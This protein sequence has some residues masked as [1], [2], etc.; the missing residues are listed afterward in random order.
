[1]FKKGISD[2]LGNK[3]SSFLLDPEYGWDAA[4]KLNDDVGLIMAYE[5]T[6]YDASE[7]G[8]LPNLVDFYAV[9]D[10]AAAGVDAIK[11]LV[12]YDIDEEEKYNYIKHVFIKRV[13]DECKQNDILFILEPVSYSAAGLDSKGAEFAKRK[14]AIVEFFVEELSKEKDGADLLTVECPVPIH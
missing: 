10:L 11:L 8:R 12:Y 2:I 6:G 13:G 5:K 7:K 9:Q 14:P 1:E 3:S 4:D